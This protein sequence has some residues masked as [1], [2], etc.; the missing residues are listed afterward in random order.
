MS[1]IS[2][3]NKVLAVSRKENDLIASAFTRGQDRWQKRR[4]GWEPGRTRYFD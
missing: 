2:E 4:L 3:G 1:A